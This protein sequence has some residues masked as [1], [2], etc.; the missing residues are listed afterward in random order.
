MEYR[1]YVLNGAGHIVDAVESLL[2]AD[3][4]A[5]AWARGRLPAMDRELWTGSRVVARLPKADG[6]AA[7]GR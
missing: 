5:I 3:A 7:A 1:L 6:L 2:D 4:Q